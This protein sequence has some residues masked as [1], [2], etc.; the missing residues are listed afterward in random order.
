MG[1]EGAFSAGLGI[2]GVLGLDVA[3][4]DVD[5]GRCV[6]DD[7]YIICVIL[8]SWTERADKSSIESPVA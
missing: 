3:S 2:G 4:L 7:L 6:L 8:M 5:A 1:A